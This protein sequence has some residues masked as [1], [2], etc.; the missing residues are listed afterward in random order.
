MLSQLFSPEVESVRNYEGI[1]PI[2]GQYSGH[3]TSILA[4]DWL[5]RDDL[6]NAFAAV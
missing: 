6:S 1:Q 4:S 5:P 3:V 2:R